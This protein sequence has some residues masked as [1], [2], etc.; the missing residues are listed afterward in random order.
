MRYCGTNIDMKQQ[1]SGSVNVNRT[2][3][4]I[5]ITLNML[6]KDEAGASTRRESRERQDFGIERVAG[7]A[8][9]DGRQ[10]RMRG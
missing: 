2:R 7:R 10:S 4:C 6:V 5:A 3:L 1:N 9:K 8:S